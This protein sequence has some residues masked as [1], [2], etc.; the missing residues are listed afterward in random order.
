MVLGK[1]FT[2]DDGEIEMMNSSWSCSDEDVYQVR[3]GVEPVEEEVEG[4][5]PSSPLHVIL[6]H[7]TEISSVKDCPR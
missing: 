7:V 1:S 2:E 6:H 4:L 5:G 3:E